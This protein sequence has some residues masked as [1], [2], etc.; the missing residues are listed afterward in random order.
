L[1]MYI[2]YNRDGQLNSLYIFLF[3]KYVFESMTNYLDG[4]L[5]QYFAFLYSFNETINVEAHAG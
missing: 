1:S 3:D 2:S 4:L 5:L